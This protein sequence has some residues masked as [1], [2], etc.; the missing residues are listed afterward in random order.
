[1]NG[2]YLAVLPIERVLQSPRV[3]TDAATMAAGTHAAAVV[4][5]LVVVSAFGAMNGIILAGPRVYLA[6]ARDGLAFQWVGALHGRFRTP[7]HAIAAQAI[8]SSVL[9]VTGTY[10][11]LFT[12][13]VYTEWLFFGALALGLLWVRRRPEYQPAF[14][15]PGGRALPLLFATACLMIVVEHIAAAP[16]ES[17]VG[18]SIVA[19]GLPVYLLVIARRGRGQHRSDDARR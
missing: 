11:G 2:A 9:V 8:W 16:I 6:M 17:L 13:V 12:R 18:L 19:A 15:L 10:R 7:H 5:T 3:A 14:R 4:G 1:L